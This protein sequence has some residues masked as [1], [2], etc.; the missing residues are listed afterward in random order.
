MQPRE[1]IW[2]LQQVTRRPPSTVKT[3]FTQGDWAD[4]LDGFRSGLHRPILLDRHRANAIGEAAPEFVTPL[5]EAA[6]QLV[7][8]RFQFF[9]Y[10][11][12][13][14][15]APINW[16]HDPLSNVSWPDTPANRIDHRTA[17]GDVKWI[18]ELNRLQHLP[19]LAQGWLFTD[20]RR[21]SRAAFDHLDSWIDQN[22]PGRGIAWRG[23]FEAGLRSISIAVAL[24]GLR[25]APELTIERYRRG[26]EGPTVR[27][28]GGWGGGG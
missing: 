24:Q 17:G 8:N 1:V 3:G 28:D 2:R 26:V 16:H 20:D 21:Y 14:L 25:D 10:P 4:S 5:L 9:G 13:T 11:P 7:G 23:A 22:P 19:L 6:D 27:A 12:V 15:T 18:W